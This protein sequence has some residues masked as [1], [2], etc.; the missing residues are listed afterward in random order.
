VDSPG[1]SIS[2]TQEL[3]DKIYNARKTKPIY[4]IADSM[5]ASAALW[6][7]S[8]A[9]HFCCTPGGEVGSVGVYCIHVDESEANKRDGMNVSVIAAGKYKMECGPFAPL[10]DEARAYLQGSVD[11]TYGKFLKAV[12]RH[13]GVSVADV[14]AKYG[15]GRL[16]NADDALKAGLID[17]VRT[18]DDLMGK[19]T[20]G[21][22]SPAA[23]A[24]RAAED[25]VRRLKYALAKQRT[26]DLI[27]PRQ[28]GGAHL[29][30]DSKVA[31]SEPEWSAV[32]KDKLPRVAFADHGDG[33]NHSTFAYPH[34]W[35][36][37]GTLGDDGVYKDGF[38]YLHR[39]GLDSAWAAAMGARSGKKAS[40]E[41]IAHLQSHRR[42]LG[43]DKND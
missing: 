2:G 7:A 30:H 36:K 11:A 23:S 31:D 6:I 41:V 34:H 24:G 5:A 15:E 42:A 8:A 9:G 37:N 33:K 13:R 32:D 35:I 12:A 20:G 19:L 3:A 25:E 40:S 28:F 39:Q 14:K 38:M 27:R 29:S 10:T 22:W 4:A 26:A 18:F 17:S 21:Q 16:L 43:L 1:G